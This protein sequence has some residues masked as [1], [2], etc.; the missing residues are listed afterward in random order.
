[1]PRRSRRGSWRAWRRRSR[2][3]GRRN[4]SRRPEASW[5]LPWSQGARPPGPPSTH[6]L[7]TLELQGRPAQALP[8]LDRLLA[9]EPENPAARVRRALVT[10]KA[11]RVDR[12]EELLEELTTSGPTWTRDLATQEFARL[13]A[14]G[15][16][17]DEA[18][19]LLRQGLREL[20]REKLSLQLA[21]LL[22]PRWTDS[23]E[24]LGVWL[25]GPR[26][27][28]PAGDS[29]PSARWIYEGGAKEDLDALRVELGSEVSGRLAG[30]ERT[31]SQLPGPA[32][33]QRK[34]LAGCR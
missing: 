33:Y 34:K 18:V 12:G 28:G 26:P 3:C 21:A 24:V 13:L 32:D 22:D 5:R 10:V 20:P 25:D 7:L 2:R 15:G 8:H 14:A 27:A 31:L 17:K 19:A 1:M 6:S 30:L 29:E 9:L 16:R 23:W 4:G 11:G